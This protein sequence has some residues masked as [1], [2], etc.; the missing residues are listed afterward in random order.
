MFAPFLGL[1]SW[2]FAST[3][4]RFT[5]VAV[6]DR[7][8]VILDNVGPRRPER[9][10]ER[11]DSL[12]ALGPMNDTIGDAWIEVNGVRYWIEGIWSSQLFYMRKLKRSSSEK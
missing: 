4:R 11:F 8:L 12:D 10:R 3:R 2:M 1:L 9:V 5:T 6:T 7:G